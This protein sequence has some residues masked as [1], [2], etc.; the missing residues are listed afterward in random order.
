MNGKKIIALIP[1]RAGSK[2][3]K[4]KN[5]KNLLGKPLIYWTIDAA[6]KSKYIGRTIV[7]TDSEKIAE[8]AR[9]F[10]AEV[11][12]IRPKEL[13]TDTAKSIDV[14]LHAIN[15]IQ[16]NENL[17]DF[18]FIYLQPT[19]PL[20]TSKDIDAA[21]EMF[22]K[23]K[24]LFLVS[25]CE[26]EHN[27]LWSLTVKDK[28]IDIFLGEKYLNENRQ[29]L[30]SFYRLNG[31]IYIGYSNGIKEKKTFITKDTLVYIM[32]QERSIDIDTELDFKIAEFLLQEAINCKIG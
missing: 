10:G 15:F 29:S 2:G 12:F 28:K 20:R 30:Q 17:D 8:I 31:A 6:K 27:P 4:N 13:S 5:I 14:I 18:I 25:V 22:I 9:K 32:P 16:K 24:S 3:V 19:S 7:S 23:E 11:P 21:L 1:A 26:A